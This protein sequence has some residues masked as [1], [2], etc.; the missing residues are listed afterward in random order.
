MYVRVHLLRFPLNDY[1]VMFE[2]GLLSMYVAYVSVF[3]SVLII[4]I[5]DWGLLYMYVS[6]FFFFALIYSHG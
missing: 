6:I 1:S 2:R 5:V 3:F 4:V